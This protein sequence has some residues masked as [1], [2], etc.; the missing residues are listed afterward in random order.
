MNPINSTIFTLSQSFSE[1]SLASN[2]HKLSLKNSWTCGLHSIYWMKKEKE[3]S[4]WEKRNKCDEWSMW[5]CNFCDELHTFWKITAMSNNYEQTV[6]RKSHFVYNC[7]IFTVTVSTGFWILLFIFAQTLTHASE[8]CRAPQHMRTHTCSRGPR[9]QACWW[10]ND[11]I[12][13]F[14]CVAN[15]TSIS[16][17]IAEQSSD[18][19]NLKK[20]AWWAE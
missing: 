1:F 14:S 10:E 3:T 7:N 2:V 16:C 20:T 6:F 18:E 13:L 17:E 9:P 8:Q 19:N 5:F 15:A 12:H 4:K 11:K